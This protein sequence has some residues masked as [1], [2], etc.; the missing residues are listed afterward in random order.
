MAIEPAPRRAPAEAPPTPP[1]R[2]PARSAPRA[3]RLWLALHLPAFPLEALCRVPARDGALAI[4][5]TIS[6]TGG[7]RARVTACDARAAAAGVRPGMALEAAF[8]LIPDLALLAR[9]E[10]REAREI[11]ALAVWAGQF[12]SLVCPLHASL[13][14]AAAGAGLLLEV[15]GSLRL[16]GGLARLIARVREGL[17]ALGYRAREAVAPTPLGAWWLARANLHDVL[18]DP[19][20]QPAALSGR[21]APVPL[22]CLDLPGPTLRALQRMGLR[23]VGDCRRLPRDGLARRLGP[24]L[25][26]RLDRAAGRRPDPRQPFV[27]PERF[28]RKLDL[29]WAVHEVEPLLFALQRLLLE[30]RGFLIARD[31]GVRELRLTLSHGGAEGNREERELSLPLVRATRDAAHLRALMRERLARLAGS[32]ARCGVEGVG[33][34]ARE[35]QPFAPG[36]PDLLAPGADA[37]VGWAALVER[38]RARL[39]DDAVNGLRPLPAHRPERAWRAERVPERDPDPPPRDP[40]RGDGSRRDRPL[41]LLATPRALDTARARP[42]IGGPLALLAGPE[43]IESGWWDGADAAR[44]YFVA[45][46]ATGETYW[47]YRDRRDPRRW[48]LHGVFA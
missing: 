12:T 39:G 47:V 25:L 14:G 7:A 5:E 31:A 30:L 19:V 40:P 23:R 15:R 26:D 1:A 38:L 29:P 24:D 36:T 33:L 46:N 32:T 43:R 11:E 4:A 18:R 34:E 37:G 17:G 35:V 2:P 9:D 42:L 22:A 27:P 45:A 16:F 6:G 21:L 41:W 28:A 44:D 48:Y 13:P 3:G 20:T 8:A 10:A